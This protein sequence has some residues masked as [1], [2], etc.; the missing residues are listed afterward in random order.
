[1][2]RDLEQKRANYAWRSIQEV[3]NFG[4]EVESKYKSYV[5]NAPSYI[6]INGLGNTLVFYKSKFESDFKK[7]IEESRKKGLNEKEAFKKLSDDKKAYKLLY[8]HL[9]G[10]FKEQFKE[11]REILYWIIDENTSS[12]DV[13]HVTKEIIA[14]LNWIKRFAEAELRDKK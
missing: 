10:W 5:K 14:L 7:Y 12:I 1:M 3:K 9:N 4:I 13:F 11:N 8:D 6:Q 2:L